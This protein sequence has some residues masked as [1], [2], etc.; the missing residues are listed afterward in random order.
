MQRVRMNFEEI[1]DSLDDG[2]VVLEN[3]KMVYFNR[4]AKECLDEMGDKRDYFFEKSG[5]TYFSKWEISQFSLNANL[6]F[7]KIV[8][9]KENFIFQASHE[10]KN[11]L[12][13]VKG[14]S[15][16]L[17]DCTSLDM[18]QTISKKIFQAAARLED[19]VAA[20]LKLAEIDGVDE[21]S[22]SK[23][24]ILDVLKRCRD[25]F[26]FLHPRAILEL[27]AD[28]IF[29]IGD[30][31]LLEAALMNL[32]DNSVKHG[33]GHVN[34]HLKREDGGARL[35]LQDRGKGIKEEHLALVFD[36]F[37]RVDK[38]VKG[39]GLGLFF[40]K[41]VIEKHRGTIKALHSPSGAHFEIIFQ[42]P[43]NILR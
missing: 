14:Y 10:I 34:L 41:K 15:E 26:L 16:L 8:N 9:S 30:A 29:I 20:L 13:I 38:K 28:S 39:H 5:K 37:Y 22:F 35:I 2:I 21:K 6:T 31:H 40:V 24:N 1:L 4:R 43:E 42:Q 11:P 17:Q 7:L 25:S 33:G 19:L 3:G 27:T 18:A 32:L 23:I 36:K 12:A